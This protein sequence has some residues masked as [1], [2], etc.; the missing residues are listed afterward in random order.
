MIKQIQLP[1]FTFTFYKLILS[2]VIHSQLRITF[3]HT[4]INFIAYFGQFS[5]MNSPFVLFQMCFS[6]TLLY[7]VFWLKSSHKYVTKPWDWSIAKVS[8]WFIWTW[9]YLS[10]DFTIQSFFFKFPLKNYFFHFFS[11]KK[12]K[13]KNIKWV[14]SWMYYTNDTN[15]IV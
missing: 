8:L 10:S 11:M 6:L 14:I 1:L 7:I 9:I 2:H 13:N 3:S 5:F 12:L 15:H 4:L